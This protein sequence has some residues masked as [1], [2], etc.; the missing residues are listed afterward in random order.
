MGA[1]VHKAA[2]ATPATCYLDL[3]PT[4]NYLTCGWHD[5]ACW[6]YPAPVASGWALDWTTSPVGSFNAF[7]YSKSSNGPGFTNTGTATVACTSGSCMNYR[8]GCS[9]SWRELARRC[10]VRSHAI[11]HNREC[12][13]HLL[14]HLSADFELPAWLYGER[15]RMRVDRLPRAPAV[16]W[17]MGNEADKQLP[18]RGLLQFSQQRRPMWDQGHRHLRH[19]DDVV[20]VLAGC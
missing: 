12:L 13:H 9:R 15:V 18:R 3:H 14:G 8:R 7:F 4:A 17:R 1:P 6:D 16:W 20:D 5:G 10:V 11:D 19:A 2:R